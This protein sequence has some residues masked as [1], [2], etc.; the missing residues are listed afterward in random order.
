MAKHEHGEDALP[1]AP[2]AGRLATI[3]LPR[4]RCPRCGG[5]ALRKYR[6][7]RDQGDGTSM[8]WVRCIK[9]EERFKVLLE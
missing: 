7:I 2:G 6:S 9:C 1:R 4:A 3:T 5:V 8:S